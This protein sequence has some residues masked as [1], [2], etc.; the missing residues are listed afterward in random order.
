[1]QLSI[2]ERL[3]LLVVLPAEES[4]ANMLILQELRAQ[5]GFS[6]ADKA[7]FEIEEDEKGNVKWNDEVD[8]RE[9]HKDIEIGT[10]GYE[11]IKRSLQD[12]SNKK[13]VNAE[14]MPVYERFV[15]GNPLIE[16]AEELTHTA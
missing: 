4:Y 5:L 11:L 8:A 10:T 9:P 2:K 14:I 6:E 7:L 3:V 16:L 1:M 13:A 12:V 15:E